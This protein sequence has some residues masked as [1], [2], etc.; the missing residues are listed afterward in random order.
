M[1]MKKIIILLLLASMIAAATP[2]Y[3]VNV[4]DKIL[5]KEVVL[6]ATSMHILVNRLTGEVKFLLLN[7]GKWILLKGALKHQ[8]QAIY[9]AQKNAQALMNSQQQ[10]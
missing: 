6:R 1:K 10:P 2:C 4:F 8:C 3:A 7:S 5:Y 9:N